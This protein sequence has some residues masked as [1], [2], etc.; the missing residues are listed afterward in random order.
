MG[1][2]LF[3]FD[4]DNNKIIISTT[5]TLEDVGGATVASTVPACVAFAE[6]SVGAGGQ[7]NFPIIRIHEAQR[8]EVRVNGERYQEGV[9]ADDNAWHRDVENTLV[10]LHETIPEDALVEIEIELAP[11]NSG[12]AVS[13]FEVGAGGQT[14]FSPVIKFGATTYMEA[15][16][17]G[18]EYREGSNSDE[19]G[20][21]R[22]TG[23]Q[24]IIFHE[25]LSEGAW[26][27]IIIYPCSNGQ[28]T[29]SPE[30]FDISGTA[31]EVQLAADIDTTQRM[32]VLVNGGKYLEGDDANDAAWHRDAATNKV[33]FH[34][35]L[36]E[37]AWVRAK[38]FAG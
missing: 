30:D 16:V 13:S 32:E 37:P 11:G 23:T 15:F 36:P 19:Y 4:T 1:R 9:D 22:D 3:A 12:Q 26:V 29:G 14:T 35:T 2:Q 34:E 7:T 6:T 21:H 20:W 28:V 27:E 33:L 10:V 17:T 5:K 25:T 38:I 8:L 18:Q 24:T 31:T